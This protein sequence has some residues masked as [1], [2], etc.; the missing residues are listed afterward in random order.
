MSAIIFISYSHPD[1]SI[2]QRIASA[3]EFAGL[4]PWIDQ[5][6]IQ[7]GDSF[8]EGMSEGLGEA[9]YV[10]LLLSR[11]AAVSKFVNREWMSALA[12]KTITL[13]PV[14][15][16]DAE[17][18]M[19][20]R[21]IVYIDLRHDL[22]AGIARVVEFFRRETR[23][24][25]VR[26]LRSTA[27]LTTASRR[28]LRLVAM[29]CLDEAGLRGFC[30]DSDIDPNRLGGASVNE[31]LLSLLHLVANEGLADRFAEWLEAER[32][33]CVRKSIEQLQTLPSWSWTV[34]LKV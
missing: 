5:Q 2:A 25:S 19:L 31:R 22:E 9:S 4:A 34:D 28:Q 26:L 30:F 32:E 7:P 29:R 23:Q 24:P 13:V 3:L 33:R 11:A 10:L 17:V 14:L 1:A 21:D 27:L 6:E 12:S 20:L 15:L 8:I 18:P 16:D